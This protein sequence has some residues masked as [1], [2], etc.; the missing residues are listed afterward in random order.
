MAAFKLTQ[1]LMLIRLKYFPQDHGKLQKSKAAAKAA[2]V[3]AAAAANANF[4]ESA[5]NLLRDD[6]ETTLHWITLLIPLPKNVS[7]LGSL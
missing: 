7:T 5:D 2:A 4:G 1:W 6:D 3:A